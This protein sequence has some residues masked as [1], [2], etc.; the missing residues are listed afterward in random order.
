MK[1]KQPRPPSTETLSRF[2]AGK[3]SDAETEELLLLLASD[4]ESLRR[5]D[6]L[7]SAQPLQTMLTNE[8][9][10]DRERSL[11]M[12]RRLIREINRTNLAENVVKFA[13]HGFAAVAAGLLRPA[14]ARKRRE[15]RARLS[16]A[17]SRY[18]SSRKGTHHD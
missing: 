2:V 8:E 7:W 15:A 5:V 12:Q 18:S 14:L 4:E 13:T 17:S 16:R 6:E 3:L 9:D 11:R 10:L 1:K